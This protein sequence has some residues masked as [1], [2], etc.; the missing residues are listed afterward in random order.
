MGALN[1]YAAQIGNSRPA[2]EAALTGLQSRA[3]IQATIL[4]TLLDPFDDPDQLATRIRTDWKIPEAK[5]V[6]ALFVKERDTWVARIWLSSD[7]SERFASGPQATLEKQV[8]QDLQQR[9]VS[10]AVRETVDALA[11]A[12]LPPEPPKPQP[13]AERPPAGQSAPTSRKSLIGWMPPV[14]FYGAVALWVTLLVVIGVR[15]LLYRFCPACA[16]RLRVR[17]GR[18]HR[19]YYCERCG[20]TYVRP[21]AR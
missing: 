8:R 5:A 15:A 2:L 10:Q 3:G 7:L 13:P 6:F 11:Q 16:G 20:A 18:A 17:Q 14:V 9:R 19:V 12:F 21:R 4:I 1:D